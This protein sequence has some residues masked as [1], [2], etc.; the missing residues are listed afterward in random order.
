MWKLKHKPPKHSFPYLNIVKNLTQK[1]NWGNKTYILKTSL[2]RFYFS[3]VLCLLMHRLIST[4]SSGEIKTLFDLTC[5]LFC[6]IVFLFK[7]HQLITKTI[8]A[9]AWKNNLNVVQSTGKVCSQYFLS[10][11]LF[12]LYVLNIL[13][14]WIC[15]GNNGYIS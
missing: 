4:K 10:K 3:K 15:W 8:Q 12:I 9:Q 11:Q 7:P 13:L 5:F 1:W 2:L 14:S 6:D